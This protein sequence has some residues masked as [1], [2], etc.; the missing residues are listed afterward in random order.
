MPVEWKYTPV[1]AL[2]A[3]ASSWMRRGATVWYLR[4]KTIVPTAA[5]EATGPRHDTEA[6]T[7]G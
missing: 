6:K 7:F 5:S 2:I 3:S 4:I 1:C